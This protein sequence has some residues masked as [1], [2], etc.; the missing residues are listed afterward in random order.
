MIA[1]LKKLKG[2]GAQLPP[3]PNNKS[4]A[5]AWLGGVLAIAALLPTPTF[6]ATPARMV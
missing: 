2:D 6:I 1:F 4:V 3:Q 5:L